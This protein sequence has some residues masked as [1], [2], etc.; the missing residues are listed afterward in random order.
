[1]TKKIIWRLKEQPTAKMLQ[2]LFTGGILTKEEA[3]EIL[4]SHTDQEEEKQI[5]ALKSEV[6]FLRE[7]VDKLSESKITKIIETIREVEKP[8]Y[9]QP[10]YRPYE[11]WCKAANTDS[12]PITSSGTVYLNSATS[13]TNLT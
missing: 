9:R 12:G 8:Y 1:M 11:V 5:E 4:L 10:W 3:K 6:K 13:F 2:D 7:M